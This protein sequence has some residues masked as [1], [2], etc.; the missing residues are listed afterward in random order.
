M[1]REKDHGSGDPTTPRVAPN[2][3]A[4]WR[5]GGISCSSTGV[6]SEGGKDYSYCVAKAGYTTCDADTPV[7]D[8]AIDTGGENADAL[9]AAIDAR[10]SC[11]SSATSSRARGP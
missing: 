1:P 3:P 6:A 8:D 9:K 2:A 5:Q 10:A 11:R 7:P 4:H